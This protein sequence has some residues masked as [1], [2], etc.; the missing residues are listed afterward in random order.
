[1]KGIK[2][3]F[4]LAGKLE[5]FGGIETHLFHYCLGMARSGANVILATT[6]RRLDGKLVAELQRAGVCVKQ[7]DCV[8]NGW[9]RFVAYAF[10]LLFCI[11]SRWSSHLLYTHSRSGF[12]WLIGAVTRPRLWVHHHH[13]D[14]RAET[15]NGL[16]PLY[17]LLLRHAHWVIACTPEHAKALD[18]AFHRS[19]RT[20][21]LPYLKMEPKE[22]VLFSARPGHPEEFVIGFFGRMLAAKGVAIIIELAPWFVE[23]GIECRLHGTD[24]EHLLAGGVP[25]GLS[26]GGQYNAQNDLDH[27]MSDIDLVIMPTTFYEGLPIVMCEAISRGIPVL[28]YDGGGLRDVRGMHVDLKVISPNVEELKREIIQFKNTFSSSERRQNLIEFYRREFG[29]DRTW[30]WWSALLELDALAMDQFTSQ[31]S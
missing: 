21:F 27:L 16:P 24:T 30:A 15:L 2:E 17:R 4:V 9:M 23:Q 29:N 8:R 10:C 11:R 19:G 5:A 13:E 18:G 3:I 14:A 26:W 1:M 7:F 20:V 31:S 6:S 22:V 12:A 25:P 28:A